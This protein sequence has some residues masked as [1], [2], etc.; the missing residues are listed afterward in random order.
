M[1]TPKNEHTALVRAAIGLLALAMLG[2]CMLLAKALVDGPLLGCGEGSGCDSVLKSRYAYV[3]P[4][5]PVT[6]PALLVY[7]VLLFCILKR[8][9]LRESGSWR[10]ATLASA[11]LIL[12]AAACFV[13]I[14]AIRLKQF[15]PWCMGT[16]LAA[17][18]AALLAVLGLRI[19]YRKSPGTLVAAGLAAGGALAAM[20]AFQYFLPQKTY[21][22]ADAG[23]SAERKTRKTFALGDATI[24]LDQMPFKGNADS[25]KL[26][27]ILF[28]YT[29]GSCRTTHRYLHRAESR[30][31][32]DNYLVV[33][34]PVPLNP[35]CNPFFTGNSPQ[36]ADACAH[37]RLALALWRLDRDAFREWDH[38]MFETGTARRA[39]SPA[40]ALARA[41]SLVDPAKLKESLADP[42]I[43]EQLARNIG[44]WKAMKAREN[45]RA[46]MPQMILGGRLILG[47]PGSESQLFDLMANGLKLTPLNQ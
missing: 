23:G 19:L 17:A 3:L 44:I 2:A 30:F 10:F 14:Q 42:W 31:G 35:K 4:G 43:E 36:H 25:E 46:S 18:A 20:L 27:V 34:I 24:D 1:K 13:A 9:S 16:H 33:G 22:T 40:D 28:D 47:A 11:F 29:C 39:P 8:G 32:T 45:N 41:E 26:M 37:S 38:W 5:V 15:C 21:V 7:A 12:G 6:V